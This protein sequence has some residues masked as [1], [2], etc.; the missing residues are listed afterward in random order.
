MAKYTVIGVEPKV[1]RPTEKNPQGSRAM[2]LHLVGKSAKVFGKKAATVTI[3]DSSPSFSQVVN[4]FSLPVELIGFDVTVDYDS[5][6]F[7]ENFELLEKLVSKKPDSAE[8][9]K[10]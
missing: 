2:E 3:Y 1:F 9:D 5:R 10:K 8:P 7:L 6:G 4:F